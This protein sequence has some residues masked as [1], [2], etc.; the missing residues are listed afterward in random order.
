MLKEVRRGL[1]PQPTSAPGPGSPLPHLHR[2]WV[3]PCHFTFAASLG[4][5]F[6][7]VGRGQL[8][9]CGMGVNRTAFN[10]SA[11]TSRIARVR[12]HSTPVRRSLACIAGAAREGARAGAADCARPC[13]MPCQDR[14]RAH[15]HAAPSVPEHP[16]GA[17]VPACGVRIARRAACS[18]SHAA[19]MRC[20]C[21]ARQAARMRI[22]RGQRRV[23]A[24]V[25]AWQP[26]ASASAAVR[27]GGDRA[28]AP[29]L[30]GRG[31]WYLM[32]TQSTPLCVLTVPHECSEYRCAPHCVD[33]A[34][35]DRSDAQLR[36]RR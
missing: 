14:C 13:C 21:D 18:S 32:S 22:Q 33:M 27:G 30:G 6:R 26:R 34:G 25:R 29:A 5:I 23:R 15:C 19:N 17:V 8:A 36:R 31:D 1:A 24:C 11:R 3:H 2:D 20:P 7:V 10:G 12:G 4:R 35:S 16:A 28:H 9:P